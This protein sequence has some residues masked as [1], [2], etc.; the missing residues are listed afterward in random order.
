MKNLTPKT[1]TTQD[2]LR[3]STIV[4]TILACLVS[5]PLYFGPSES[6]LPRTWSAVV[7]ASMLFWGVVS[8]LAFH[9]FWD[10][11][12]QYIYPAWLKHWAPLNIIIYGSF[13]Y[14]IWYLTVQF[15]EHAGLLF[16]I[17]GGLEGVLEH[18][19]GIYKLD[20]LEKVPWLRGLRI[21]PVLLF[22]FVEYVV[23]WAIV[24][25]IA[26]AIHALY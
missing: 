1:P 24:L 13:A 15:T 21:P 25:W 19:W 4:F 17:I 6:E 10:I 7:V 16:V 3:A 18:V 23:Y 9:F 5:L 2:E 14:G 11:Y 26:R 8:F 20:V 12:Y 22:S